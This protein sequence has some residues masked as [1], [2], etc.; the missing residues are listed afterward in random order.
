[1]EVVI[2]FSAQSG[3]GSHLRTSRRIPSQKDSSI[4]T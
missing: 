3:S 1:M 4:L 2:N